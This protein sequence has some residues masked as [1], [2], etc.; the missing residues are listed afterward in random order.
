MTRRPPALLLAVGLFTVVPVRAHD[1]DRDAARRLILALPWL[2]LLLGLGAGALA[3]GAAA[4]GAGALLASAVA[5]TALALVTGAM[6]LDGLADT[7]DGIGSRKPPEQAVAIMKRSD[8]GPMGVATV[9]LVLLLGAAALASPRVSSPG[10]WALPAA[11]AAAAMTGRLL[12]LAATT[13]RSPAAHGSGF[14]QLFSG[15]TSGRGLAISLVAV[16]V[17]DCLLGYGASGLR[18]VVVFATAGAVAWC[19]GL[20]WRSRVIRRLGGVNG[21]VWGSLIELGQLAFWLILA[22][23]L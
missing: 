15:V 22:V 18:G 16:G 6:H 4:L 8:I 1:L 12:A 14:A 17:A 21:D 19:V 11:V 23:A 3:W 20:Y 5:L 7:A 9:V 10:P 13:T 2:G